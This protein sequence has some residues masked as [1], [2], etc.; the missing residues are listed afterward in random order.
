MVQ[1]VKN[2]A[3]PLLR[4]GFQP[5]PENFHVPWVQPEKNVYIQ[6][7]P[8]L[9]KTVMFNHKHIYGEKIRGEKM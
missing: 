9:V 3:L 5:W 4:C 2:L 8:Y 6:N 7:D 1:R